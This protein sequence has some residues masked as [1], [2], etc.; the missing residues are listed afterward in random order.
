MRHLI[1]LVLVV[2]ALAACESK[3]VEQRC[4]EM[5][6]YLEERER[7]L[8]RDCV[9]DTDCNV[10]FIRPGGPIA[11]NAL[12]PDDAALARVLREFEAQC[13]A[14]P[15]GEGSVQAICLERIV[16]TPSGGQERL[17]PACT[18]RGEYVVEDVGV[19]ALEDVSDAGA[20]CACERDSDCAE[21]TCVAC[22][23][24]ASGVCA[25]A[26]AQ[27]WACDAQDTLGLGNTPSTCA[28]GCDAAIQDDAAF[29]DFAE[30]LRDASCAGI[31]DCARE[32]P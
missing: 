23:C 22:E 29:R 28:A 1:S 17:S 11:V 5:Y 25:N 24:L 4:D 19:D 2:L 14:L 3:A 9:V 21:G 32:V 30:C 7:D 15:R 27:A 10:V 8:S 6:T 18:L 20:V 12:Q 13:G 26:C 16:D 31:A